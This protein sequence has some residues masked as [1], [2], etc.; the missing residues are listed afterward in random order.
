MRLSDVCTHM[1]LRIHMCA[2]VCT[3]IC[4]RMYA[5]ICVCMYAS[6]YLY[7]CVCMRL[8]TIHMYAPFYHPYVCAYLPPHAYAPIYLH[9]YAPIHLRMHT[10]LTGVIPFSF[11]FFFKWAPIAVV[12]GVVMLLLYIF[13]R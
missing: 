1:R 7:V 12:I 3:Y 13:W 4:V 9:M 2:Y 5:P 10:Y 8:S 6:I 11:F